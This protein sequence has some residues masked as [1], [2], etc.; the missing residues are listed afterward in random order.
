MLGIYFEN[1]SAAGTCLSATGHWRTDKGAKGTIPWF[2]RLACIP[3][4][5][6]TRAHC[7]PFAT[8]LVVEKGVHAH[9]VSLSASPVATGTCGRIVAEEVGFEPTV[10]FHA[11]RFSRPV[12]S[13]T[14]PLLRPGLGIGRRV[15]LK[16][17]G[18]I[19]PGPRESPFSCRS[20][21][22]KHFS[23]CRQESAQDGSG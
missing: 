7:L 11:R 10:R 16:A 17:P 8:A 1:R 14:L 6:G 2:D 12:H 5:S 21:R 15:I 4:P 9:S 19:L 20:A 18:A 13:T 22:A 3:R 23:Q